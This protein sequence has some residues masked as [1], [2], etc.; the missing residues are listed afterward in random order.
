M[1]IIFYVCFLE[2]SVALGPTSKQWDHSGYHQLNGLKETLANGDKG[3][4]LERLFCNS[5]LMLTIDGS[6]RKLPGPAGTC[7]S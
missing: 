2:P 3:D 6:K 5:S 4:I 1:Q 7:F